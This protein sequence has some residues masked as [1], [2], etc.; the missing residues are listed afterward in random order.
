[1]NKMFNHRKP[2]N[3]ENSSTY[4]VVISYLNEFECV[5]IKVDGIDADFLEIKDFL[6]IAKQNLPNRIQKFR[7]GE[8]SIRIHGFYLNFDVYSGLQEKI[9]FYKDVQPFYGE[10][11][12]IFKFSIS[13]NKINRSIRAEI[14]QTNLASFYYMIAKEIDLTGDYDSFNAIYIDIFKNASWQKKLD[15][16]DL[17]NEQILSVKLNRNNYKYSF[18]MIEEKLKIKNK[19]L[20]SNKLPNSK[21]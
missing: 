17:K 13:F 1:M 15:D 9:S 11:E 2:E 12:C 6:E 18:L 14:F 5:P 4:F 8:I 20:L 19:F 16:F 10:L 3:Q 7:N 21:S